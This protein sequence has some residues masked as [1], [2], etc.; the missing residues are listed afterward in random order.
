MSAVHVTNLT[1]R[2]GQVTALD[3]VS[4]T[5]EENSITGILGRNG[6][7]KTVLMSILTAQE[8]PTS[9][10]VRVFGENPR[11]NASV[12]SRTCFI[13]DTQKYPDEFKLRHILGAGPLFYPHWDA[14]L[15]DQIVTE[16]R[17]SG[18]RVIRKM[19]RGQ[20]SAVGLLIGMASRA[21]LTFFDEPYLGLDA[22]ART[23]FYDMLL[24]DYARHPRTILISTHLID[25]MESLLERIVLLDRGR[26]RKEGSVDDLRSG[27]WEISGAWAALEP[28]LT[29]RSVLRQ[30]RMG[31][32]GVAIVE[33]GPELADD[34]RA[35][36]LRAT[37]SSLHELVA[38]YGM[39]DR[40]ET[41]E[42]AR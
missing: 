4:L 25:E 30:K 2:Y 27:G 39:A 42:V 24:A 40:D 14:R 33:A 1:T 21:P 29:G 38:A 20:L 8:V 26:V 9:G 6:A 23:V 12:L 19:S 10:S 11:E 15:A 28:L 22:T 16:F 3:G 36:G 41:A 35:L 37:P 31:A 18:D 13:R 7:G 17:L 34:A 5:I 32:L